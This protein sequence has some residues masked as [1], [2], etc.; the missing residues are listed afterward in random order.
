MISSH[1]N[2]VLNYFCGGGHWLVQMEWRP[3]GWS[4]CLPLLTFPCTIVSPE[5]LFWHRLTQVVLEKW[6]LNVVCVCVVREKVFVRKS[7]SDAVDDKNVSSAKSPAEEQQITKEMT[8]LSK[9]TE[10]GTAAIVLRDLRKKRSESPTLDPRNA[11]RTPSAAI[12]PS[13]KPRYRTPYFACMSEC[14]NYLSCHLRDVIISP[15]IYFIIR[16]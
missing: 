12:E 14:L 4:V 5:V 16:V 1:Y 2:V 9:M 10:S 15:G 8:E 7:E 6:P 3:A 13:N 11:S